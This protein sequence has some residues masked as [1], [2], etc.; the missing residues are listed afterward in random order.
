MSHTND[1]MHIRRYSLL[2]PMNKFQPYWSEIVLSD[3]HG[4]VVCSWLA[5]MLVLLIRGYLVYFLS[6]AFAISM[7]LETTWLEKNN[8]QKA[9]QE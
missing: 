3:M 8:P 7:E 6:L 1:Q 4:V 9:G 2:N 5:K